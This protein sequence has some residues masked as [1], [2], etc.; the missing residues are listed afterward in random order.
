MNIDFPIGKKTAIVGASGAGKSTIAQLLLRFYTP[1]KGEIIIDGKNYLNYELSDYRNKIGIVPQEVFLFGG[2]I[3]ENIA[4]GAPKAERK[5]IL[6]AV[7]IANV[8]EFSEKFTDGLETKVGDRGV[9]LSGGQKQR[10]AI[11]RAI[12]KNPELLILDEATSALDNQT[13][14]Q[15]QESL[16][17]LQNGRTS[18]V[19]AHRLTT[20]KDADNILVMDQGNIIESGI[21]NELMEKKGFYYQLYH[22][23]LKNTFSH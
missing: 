14:K 4:Y 6:A 10:I 11:A 7:E 17:Y 20:I 3:Y 18:I 2:T 15:L 12:L 13:E 19:I 8:I 23:Q 9:Q 5:R 16:Q 21:H 1:Q 22:S